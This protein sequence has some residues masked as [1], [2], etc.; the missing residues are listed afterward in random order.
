[1]KRYL[2]FLTTIIFIFSGTVRA[3]NVYFDWPIPVDLYDPYSFDRP[4]G[5]GVSGDHSGEDVALNPG[6]SIGAVGDGTIKLYKKNGGCDG[7]GY[8]GY[9]MLYAVAHHSLNRLI[10]IPI[11]VNTSTIIGDFSFVYGHISN[12]EDISDSNSSYT[13]I[14]IN[15]SYRTISINS[16]QIIGFIAPDD[17]PENENEYCHLLNYNGDG[18]EHLHL[19]AVSGHIGEPYVISGYGY[20]GPYSAPSPGNCRFSHRGLCG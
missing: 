18:A 17:V 4:L 6:T 3:D 2:L 7:G 20:P 11:G 15:S 19:G 5:A 13:G 14:E 8:R 12:Y 9:G 16:R 10:R 1:M